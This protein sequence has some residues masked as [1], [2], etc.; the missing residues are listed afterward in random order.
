MTPGGKPPARARKPTEPQD[1]LA[2]AKQIG[3]CQ[4]PGCRPY[5]TGR[6]TDPDETETIVFTVS[7]DMTPGRYAASLLVDGAESALLDVEFP[8]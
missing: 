8:P 6:T 1:W 2:A 5:R 7:E 4:R 3:M